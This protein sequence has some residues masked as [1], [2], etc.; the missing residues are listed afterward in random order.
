MTHIRPTRSARLRIAATLATSLAAFAAFPAPSRADAPA[1]STSTPRMI[2]VSFADM[3]QRL[4]PAVVNISISGTLRPGQDEQ[5]DGGGNGEE[6][7]GPQIPQF[8]PGSPMDRFFHQFMDHPPGEEAEPRKIQALGSGF[9]IDPAGY[10]VT[11][12]HVVAEADT[13]SVTLQDNTVLPAKIV[14]RDPSTDLA[15]LKVESKTPL[16]AV[17]FGDSDTAR[18][19]DWVLAIGNPF[20]LSGTV[21]A[22][23]VSSRGR[24]IQAGLYDDFIQTDASINRGNSGGPLFDLHGNVIGINTMIYAASGGSVGIGFA[25]PSDDARVVIDQLRKTGHVS[26]GWIGVKVQNVTPEI[27]SSLKLSPARG[28]Q[29]ASVDDKGPA[30]KAGLQKDDV[31]QSVQG[32]PIEGHMLPRLIAQM[33]PGSTVDLGI[34]RKGKTMTI[35]VTVA[36]SPDQPAPPAKGQKPGPSEVSLAPL[37][38]SVALL[39]DALRQKNHLG[40]D[41]RGVLV[42]AVTSG[43]PA[44]THGIKVGD[45][46]TE[47]GQDEVDT[48]D[49]VQ[50]ALTRA[51]GQKARSILLLVQ[52]EAG[53]RWVPFPLSP[54]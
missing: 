35:T 36:R 25:I 16:P 18:V 26:R 7:Q 33:Q 38:L 17:P 47:V 20:G 2:P 42:S 13:V 39:D 28:A 32:K 11:N 1:P 52:N 29:I 40:D 43:G 53:L 8:P 45:L 23:I 4:L 46:V 21:T 6:D 27:A 15:L 9:I 31:V 37:G 30:A 3:A 5:D 24:D 44:A 12:N 14:G 51:Q 54:H 10:V 49:A 34:W 48:P 19:G 50:Q 41:Q 22:G